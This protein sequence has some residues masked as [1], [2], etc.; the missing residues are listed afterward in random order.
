MDQTRI[1]CWSCIQSGQLDKNMEMGHHNSPWSSLRLRVHQ[2]IELEEQF[3]R[4]GFTAL[5]L[6]VWQGNEAEYIIGT[7]CGFVIKGIFPPP[8]TRPTFHLHYL[9]E[10]GTAVTNIPS[11]SLNIPVNAYMVSIS[12]IRAT[13]L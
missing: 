5:S 4:F 11:L 1:I 9:D 12:L 10:Q 7:N 2:I 6:K 8:D 3:F 13:I